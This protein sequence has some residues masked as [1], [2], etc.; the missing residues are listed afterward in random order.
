MIDESAAD[1]PESPVKS[2]L[3]ADLDSGEVI[4]ARGAHRRLPPASTIKMLTALT[5]LP[6]VESDAVYTATLRDASAIG[7]RV[8]VVEGSTYTARQ[9]LEAMFLTSGND[10]ANALAGA[11]GNYQ[12]TL[13]QMQAEAERL[14]AYNT[15]VRNPSGLDSPGQVST[16]YDLALIARAGMADPEFTELAALTDSTFPHEGTSDPK[17][18]P[19]FEIWNQ[20]TLV[21]GAYEG[22]IG[23]KSGFTT[24]AGRTL[25]AAAERNGQRYLVT[26]MGIDG[27][28][29]RTGAEYLDWAFKHAGDLEP[30]GTLV[31][32]ISWAANSDGAALIPADAASSPAA[33]AAPATDQPAEA[34]EATDAS[35]QAPASDS[36]PASFPLV[37]IVATTALSLTVWWLVRV[38]YKRA[39]GRR[40]TSTETAGPDLTEQ[41]QPDDVEV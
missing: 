12:R 8:G 23:V 41:D 19:T 21:N 34:T 39:L 6:R 33:T 30:V 24:K 37:L 16:A 10:A 20:N 35:A 29:Y 1:L 7:S 22:G 9:L 17:Q 18:R 31:G 32:P 2:F 4:A 28:T 36:E 13:K 3:I 25:A 11:N 5:V 27:N 14:Q 40:G 38:P 15:V 26:L